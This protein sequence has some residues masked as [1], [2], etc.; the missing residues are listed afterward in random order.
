VVLGWGLVWVLGG[1]PSPCGS[2]SWL[3]P[4]SLPSAFQ[5]WDTAGQERFRSVTHAYYRDAHGKHGHRRFPGS[6]LPPAPQPEPR[7]RARGV[8]NRQSRCPVGSS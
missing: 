1:S 7:L 4:P 8:G 3:T 2:R 6:P 5:I